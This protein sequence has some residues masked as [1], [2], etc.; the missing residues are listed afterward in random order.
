MKERVELGFQ[1]E[2]MRDAGA[3]AAKSLPEMKF[4]KMVEQTNNVL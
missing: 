2:E 4:H 3:F 1:G